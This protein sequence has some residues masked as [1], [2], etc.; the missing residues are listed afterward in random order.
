MQFTIQVSARD[1]SAKTDDP[2]PP[3]GVSIR[4]PMLSGQKDMGEYTLAFVITATA[5]VSAIL[6][7]DWLKNKFIKRGSKS[8][9]IDRHHTVKTKGEIEYV[10]REKIEIKYDD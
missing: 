10:L 5:S 6:I 4:G 2:T 1:W 8:I 7:A 3:E 9:T